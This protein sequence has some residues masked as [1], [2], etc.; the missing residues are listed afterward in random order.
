VG[1]GYLDECSAAEFG[2]G[3]SALCAGGDPRLAELLAMGVGAVWLP[4]A[5]RIGYEAFVAMWEVLSSSD[6]VADDR[7][8]VCVPRFGTYLRYQRNQL[9]RTM[10]ADGLS[11]SEIRSE[12]QRLVGETLGRNHITRI[13]KGMRMGEAVPTAEIQA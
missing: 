12:L 9:I 1:G 4:V 11:P 13:L 3:A 8:R 6:Q 7:Y 5:S 2:G 10:H